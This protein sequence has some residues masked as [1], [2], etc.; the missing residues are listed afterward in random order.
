MTDEP[1]AQAQ[2]QPNWTAGLQHTP[3]TVETV[4]AEP[5]KPSESISTAPKVSRVDH[6]T[7]IA[8][9]ARGLHNVSP[10]GAETVSAK[11]LQHIEDIRDPKAYDE[12]MAAQKKAVL[13]VGLIRSEAQARNSAVQLQGDGRNA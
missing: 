10:S 2:G 12:R 11:I 7:E 6:L 5:D 1:N 9:L 3:P 8:E 13:T 4:K